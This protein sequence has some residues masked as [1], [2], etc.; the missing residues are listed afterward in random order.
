[1]IRK[2]S[3]FFIVFFICIQAYSQSEPFTELNFHVPDLLSGIME[4]A[5]EISSRTAVLHDAASGT[6]LYAKRPNELIPP[7]SLTKLMT[8]HLI[9]KE[10]DAG[11]ASFDDLI[12]ITEE[13]WAQNQPERSS[14]MFLEPGQ[15]VTL[16]EI[17]LGLAVSSGNDAAVAAA[18]RF[19]PTIPDF[20]EMMNQEGRRLGL[21]YTH[22]VE[23]SGISEDN[24]TTA[25]DY[26][27]FCGCYLSLHPYST[28]FHST[29]VFA[30]PTAANVR[31]SRLARLNTI[32]QYNRNPLLHT[33]PGVDGLKT[34]FI[35]ESGHNIA[36]TAQRDNTRFIAVILGASGEKPREEDSIKLLSWAFNN[37]KT[38]RPV[39][40]NIEAV[41][42]WKGKDDSVELKLARSAVFTSP[43]DRSDEL[44]YE[45]VIRN[46]LI[47]PLEENFTA[48]YLLI[49]DASGEVNRVPL[50]PAYRCERGNI[51][52][53]YWHTIVLYV[54]RKFN[55]L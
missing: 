44:Y 46:P 10:I 21:Q 42:I 45:T 9:F 5:P 13:S 1:M 7:A 38:V 16:R 20:A 53:R 50:V 12:P 48:G 19:A 17:I 32:V 4:N 37:F 18:L 39:T 54:L 43:L 15:K 29:P 27:Y 55:K 28:E 24:L 36:L 26:A 6:V 49:H 31:E 35:Y 8:M 11:R 34:G 23:P 2:R 22:F 25:A 40:P 30:F 47:A 14:L 33:F 41:K 51:F 52:K 3:Y